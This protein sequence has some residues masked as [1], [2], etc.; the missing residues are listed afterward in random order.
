MQKWLF[1][2]RGYSRSPVY[3]ELLLVQILRRK[4]FLRSPKLDAASVISQ[5]TMAI[6][7]T[8]VRN[9]K[10]TNLTTSLPHAVPLG[11]MLAFFR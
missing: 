9:E 2:M 5:T 8:T 10:L 4:Q 1:R 6:F 11:R 7:S 3:P